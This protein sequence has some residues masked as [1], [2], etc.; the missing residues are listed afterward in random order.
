MKGG[1]RKTS[2]TAKARLPTQTVTHTKAASLR[3]SLMGMVSS[4]T[5][6]KTRTRDTGRLDFAMVLA[7]LSGTCRV[8]RCVCAVPACVRGCVCTCVRV[9]VCVCVCLREK[10]GTLMDDPPSPHN[11]PVAALLPV[12]GGGAA[13]PSQRPRFSRGCT[14]LLSAIYADSCCT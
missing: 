6:I 10:S 8:Q 5:R 12:A 9:W 13:P 11:P 4:P 2:D 1:G 14:L 3:G 7:P